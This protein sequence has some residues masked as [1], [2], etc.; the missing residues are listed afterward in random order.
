MLPLALLQAFFECILCPRGALY[1]EIELPGAA[2]GSP[3]L[4]V[5]SAHTTSGFDVLVEGARLEGTPLHAGGNPMA[6]AQVQEWAAHVRRQVLRRRS[7]DRCRGGQP[8][9]ENATLHIGTE[10]ASAPRAAAAPQG[11]PSIIMCGDLNMTPDSREYPMAADAVHCVGSGGEPVLDSFAGKW[12][13]TFGASDGEGNSLER[14]LTNPADQ[15]ADKSYDYIFSDAKPCRQAT[16][17]LAAPEA[18]HARYQ[19]VSDHQAVM[20]TWEWP[21]YM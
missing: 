19:Q 3:P 21:D 2:A 20:A 18:A 17:P 7:E 12:E 16:D 5:C 14:L 4:H 13:P 10:P 9:A 1:A 6:L 11:R 15:G 8:A